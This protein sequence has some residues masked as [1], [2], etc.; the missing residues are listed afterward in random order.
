MDLKT[1]I[2]SERGTATK[3]AAALGVSLSYLSQMSDGTSA[4]NPKRCVAIEEATDGSVTR[5]DLRPDDW[6]QIWPELRPV[7][8]EPAAA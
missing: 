6:S 7:S 1:Y 8:P 3:L 2:L 5:K 4:I